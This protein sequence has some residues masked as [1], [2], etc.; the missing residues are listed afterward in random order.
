M[1]V[2]VSSEA[3]NTDAPEGSRY[4]FVPHAAPTDEQSARVSRTPK[5]DDG[6]EMFPSQA[7]LATWAAAGVGGELGEDVTA[8]GRRSR[9]RRATGASA[10]AD[11]QRGEEATTRAGGQDQQPNLRDRRVER[12]PQRLVATVR[13]G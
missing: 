4:S 7:P 13:S 2:N 9:R 1:P 12:I 8:D 5:D 10:N 11:D 3:Q 6:S